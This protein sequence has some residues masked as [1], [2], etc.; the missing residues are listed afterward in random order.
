MHQN[1]CCIACEFS[2]NKSEKDLL[3]NAFTIHKLTTQYKNLTRWEDLTKPSKL[4]WKHLHD[5][6]VLAQGNMLEEFNATCFNI[7]VVKVGP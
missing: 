4:G 5:E 7:V 1:D 6:W 2:N 3:A